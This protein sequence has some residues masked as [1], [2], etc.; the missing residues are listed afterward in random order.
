[1]LIFIWTGIAWASQ[2]YYLDVEYDATGAFLRVSVKNL[3]G[4]EKKDDLQKIVVYYKGKESTEE[5]LKNEDSTSEITKYIPLQ[6]KT[7]D[8]IK[9]D[10]L[11]GK[12][13]VITQKVTVQEPDSI[14][15]SRNIQGVSEDSVLIGDDDVQV[16]DIKEK[17][18][19]N[20][21]SSQLILSNETNAEYGYKD[22]GYKS[23]DLPYGYKIPDP[24][25]KKKVGVEQSKEEYGYTSKDLPYGYIKKSDDNGAK[26]GY[27][28]PAEK[29]VYGRKT[30]EETPTTP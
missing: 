17:P 12:D 16:T 24:T 7:G 20:S 14:Y 9:V 22:L 23:K 1:M 28:Y 26:S 27:G 10:L 6:A 2:E 25:E 21:H 18:Q 3:S 15:K 30:Y 4:K 8:L 5:D 19:V 13:R 11:Y 29:N